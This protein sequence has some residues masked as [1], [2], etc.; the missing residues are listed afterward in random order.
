MPPHPNL[1]PLGHP[2]YIGFTSLSWMPHGH[3]MAAAAP[4]IITLHRQEA[5]KAKSS[6]SVF[7]SGNPQQNSPYTSL[8]ISGSHGRPQLPGNWGSQYLAKRKGIAVIGLIH[9]GF[10]HWAGA[11][12]YLEQSQGS[13]SRKGASLWCSQVAMPC[14]FPVRLTAVH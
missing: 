6:S 1:L 8:A 10:M 5:G 12:C 3:K 11:L 4:G 7:H 2:Q 9:S 14:I 13:V